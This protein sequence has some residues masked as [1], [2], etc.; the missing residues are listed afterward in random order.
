[1]R[2]VRN[3]SLVTWECWLCTCTSELTIGIN[4]VRNTHPQLSPSVSFLSHNHFFHHMLLTNCRKSKSRFRLC[5]SHEGPGIGITKPIGL[6]KTIQSLF[7]SAFWPN[8]LMPPL[9]SSTEETA[10]C[11]RLTGTGF[12]P[13]CTAQ[14]V[15]QLFSGRESFSQW[16]PSEKWM[17]GCRVHGC[18]VLS[19]STKPRVWS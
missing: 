15:K 17:W 16:P 9:T 3:S 4:S 19:R 14:M 7:L 1:M 8:R 10:P 13:E 5:H 2:P 11:P 6:I 18:S 12:Q